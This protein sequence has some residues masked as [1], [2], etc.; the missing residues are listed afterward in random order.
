[1]SAGAAP[2]SNESFT[3]LAR[4]VDDLRDLIAHEGVRS[5]ELLR[6]AIDAITAFQRVHYRKT[7]T[8]VIRTDCCCCCYSYCRRCTWCWLLCK[9]IHD[10]LHLESCR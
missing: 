9:W 4:R 2:E 3:D 5:Q 6:D 8:I 10:H 7:L 1:M